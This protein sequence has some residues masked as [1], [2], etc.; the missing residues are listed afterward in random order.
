MYERHRKMDRKGIIRE[1]SRERSRNKIIKW[2][3][4]ER[5]RKK[6]RK[7]WRRRRREENENEEERGI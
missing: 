1:I 4:K 5:K 7:S 2:F 6:K 3:W